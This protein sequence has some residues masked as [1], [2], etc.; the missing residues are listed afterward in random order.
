MHHRHTRHGG[1]LAKINANAASDDLISTCHQPS[2]LVSVRLPR[3]TPK[4]GTLIIFF[5]DRLELT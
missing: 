4:W 2:D 3:N 5:P 1:L